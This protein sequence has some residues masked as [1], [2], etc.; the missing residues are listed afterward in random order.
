M[1]CKNVGRMCALLLRSRKGEKESNAGHFD[2]GSNLPKRIVSVQE[3]FT[4]ENQSTIK[5]WQIALAHLLLSTT[6]SSSILLVASNEISLL[7]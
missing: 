3:N 4:T 1:D 2:K 7:L 6:T 5:S